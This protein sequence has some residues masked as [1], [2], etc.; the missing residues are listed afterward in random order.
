MKNFFITQLIAG[1]KGLGSA[2]LS[3]KDVKYRFFLTAQHTL[4][5]ELT[6]LKTA[7]LS[8]MSYA[9]INAA[10]NAKKE[11]PSREGNGQSVLMSE[12]I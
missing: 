6:T 12:N 9:V 11:L 1:L 4:T 10:S 8:E 2:L 5:Y 3:H 7:Y